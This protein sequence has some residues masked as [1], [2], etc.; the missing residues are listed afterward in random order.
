MQE[1]NLGIEEGK[2]LAFVTSNLLEDVKQEIIELLKKYK[3]CFAWSYDKMSGLSK[4]LVEYNLPIEENFQPLNQ[5]P[6]HFML[7]IA[8]KI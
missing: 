5:L 1:V 3:D 7:E 2:T 4:D 8:L 6:K